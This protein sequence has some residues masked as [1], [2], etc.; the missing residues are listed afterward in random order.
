MQLPQIES[1][2]NHDH[3]NRVEPRGPHYPDPL[4]P[5]DDAAATL[6]SSEPLSVEALQPYALHPEK[7]MLGAMAGRSLAMQ[8]L[9]ARMRCTAPHFR[10]VTVE[11]EPGTGKL[12]AAQTLHRI[13]P[14]SA[15]PFAPALASD[16]LNG[17]QAFWKDS[18]GGLAYLSRVD[19][20]SPDQQRLLRDFLERAAH[21][22]LRHLRMPGPLQIVVGASHSLRRLTS[23]GA[24]RSDLAGHLTAIRFFLPPLRDRRDDLPLLAALFLRQWSLLH[25][26]LL[27]GF[28]PGTLSRLAAHVWPGNVRELESVISTAALDCPGQ[29]IRP[30][31]VPR[32]QWSTPIP[33]A[34]DFVSSGSSDGFTEDPNLDRAILHHITRVLARVNGNKVRAARLLGISRSTLYRL[35]DSDSSLGLAAH[36]NPAS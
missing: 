35:L 8:Q 19:E 12:L 23:A 9:F 13:G 17:P 2:T 16:F 30:L 27:R 28:A 34:A 31:D 26:K 33:P 14:S 3:S 36:P 22:R 11:G 6:L 24:F 32:L 18:A 20:L 5:A 25:G 10:L 1:Q 21:E 4:L 15:G 29:W 7:W